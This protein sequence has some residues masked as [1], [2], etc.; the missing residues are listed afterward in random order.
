[1]S[2]GTNVETTVS[3]QDPTL[4][5]V[6]GKSGEDKQYIKSLAHAIVTVITKHGYA[7]LKCVGASAVNNAIKSITI[8]SG[9]AKTKGVNLVVSPAFGGASFDHTEKTAMMLS[10]F[11]R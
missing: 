3:Y 6:K 10:V 1:M 5:L 2:E 11:N 4:L 8:A 9:E 7:T